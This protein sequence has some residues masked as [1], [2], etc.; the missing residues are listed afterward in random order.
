MVIFAVVG[1][2]IG[3][4]FVKDVSELSVRVRDGRCDSVNPKNTRLVSRGVVLPGT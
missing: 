3:G 2:Y 4:Y 1:E